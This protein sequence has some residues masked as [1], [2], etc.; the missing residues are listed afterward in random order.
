MCALIYEA[1]LEVKKFFVL[2]LHGATLGLLH[3]RRL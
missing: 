1:I 2:F 3:Y